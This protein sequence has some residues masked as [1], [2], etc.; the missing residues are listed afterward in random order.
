M[1]SA[2]RTASRE[3][4]QQQARSG[5]GMLP[6]RVEDES[7]REVGVSASISTSIP[8]SAG[9]PAQVLPDRQLMSSL[10]TDHSCTVVYSEPS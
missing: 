6:R 10:F 4:Q 8:E 5:R 2:S 7:R 9:A 3:Q 1:T